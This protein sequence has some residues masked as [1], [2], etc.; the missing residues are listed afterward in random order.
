ML[1]RPVCVAGSI[2]DYQ[3]LSVIKEVEP[4][5]FTIGG[6]FFENKFPGSFNEQINVVCDYFE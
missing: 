6:A 3:R 5:A 4:W 1:Q 2:N